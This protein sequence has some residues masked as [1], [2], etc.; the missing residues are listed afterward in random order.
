MRKVSWGVLS[1]A[2][3]GTQKVIPAMQ[4]GK[5]T[6]I[7]AIASRD[8]KRAQRTAKEIGIPKAYGS[9][10]E[11]LADKEIEA[12]Y[13]PLPNHLHVEWALK[14]LQAGKH[15]L[16]EKPIAM[17]SAAAEHLKN[18]AKKFPQYKLM[19]AFMYRH[20]P[21]TLKIKSLVDSEAIGQLRSVH[22]MFSYFNNNPKDIRNMADI[23]GGGLLDIGCYCVS[24]SRFLFG[25]EPNQVC[26]SVEFDPV[27]KVDR[28]AS[29]VLEFDKGIASLT[30]A[31][32][33]A[34]H[35]YAKI[36][37]TR[38]RIEIETP[39]TPQPDRPS[40][41]IQHINSDEKE[42]TFAA[43]DQYTIQGDVFS[44]AIIE[45]KPVPTPIE[46]AVANMKVIDAILESAKTRKW[47]TV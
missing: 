36:F 24:I 31:T 10:E 16:C 45:G 19:E 44:Q 43:C 21:Q 37:G 5:Y 17:N 6:Q 28:L 13:I 33:L 47:V 4:K 27:L 26:G 23:G 46:D 9:Y 7:G 39:F 42:F 38:G 35:Q 34:N 14:S 3:I 29:A 25:A 32:Q 41:I 18:E 22:S 8:I 20:H 15:V 30:C 2:R 11:L 1:T 12:V 40:K